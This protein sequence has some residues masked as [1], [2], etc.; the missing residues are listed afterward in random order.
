MFGGGGIG[1][2]VASQKPYLYMNNIREGTR[3]LPDQSVRERTFFK[4][5]CTLWCL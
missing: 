3:M 5:G 4:N 2:L 1:M